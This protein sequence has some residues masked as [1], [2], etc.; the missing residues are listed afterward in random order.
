MRRI[1]VVIILF[2]LYCGSSYGQA[3][4]DHMLPAHNVAKPFIDFDKKGFLIN[5]KRTFL[6]SAGLE[7]TRVP[8]QLWNDR[9][10]RLKRA[11]FNC[12]EIYTFWNI[13]EPQEG[14][15]DFTGDYDLNAFLS[16]VKELGMYAIVRV[17][18]YYCA[19]WDFG[20][21]PLWLKF[22]PDVRVREDNAEFEK[23]V[24]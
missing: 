1:L 5:G 3:I 13:H 6:A 20:G 24:D 8:R 19:E 22:K 15:F 18:P 21:Y 12:V 9:L 23:Y 11:G 7:Y 14:K 4:N 10:L 17:G 2:A 16:L